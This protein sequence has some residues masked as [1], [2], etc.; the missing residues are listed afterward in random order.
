M[1]IDQL[2]KELNKKNAQVLPIK[3]PANFTK[4]AGSKI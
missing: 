1:S 2:Y 4:N 3:K